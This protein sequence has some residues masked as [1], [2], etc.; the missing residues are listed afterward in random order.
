MALFLMTFGLLAVGQLIYLGAGSGALARSKETASIA[1]QD[2]LESLS[3]LYRGDPD[4][5]EL[6]IGFHGPEQT[7]CRN[8]VT[9]RVLNRF[10]LTWDIRNVPDPRAGKDLPAKLVL[11]TVT[12]VTDQG[13]ANEKPHLNKTLTTSYLLSRKQ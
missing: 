6:S 9:G 8:P 4:S 10:E 7:E 11:I 13:I 1:A 12:P 2:K 5:A 3:G